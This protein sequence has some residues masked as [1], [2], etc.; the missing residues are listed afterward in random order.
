MNGV[1]GGMNNVNMQNM[2]GMQ[3]MNGMNM[4]NNGLYVPKSGGT[5]IA[6]IMQNK[7]M[8]EGM[9][10]VPN[11][12]VSGVNAMNGMHGNRQNI[13]SGGRGTTSQYGYTVDQNG[14]PIYSGQNGGSANQSRNVQGNRPVNPRDARYYA[15]NSRS[16]YSHDIDGRARVMELANDVNESLDALERSERNKRGDSESADSIDSIRSRNGSAV[17]SAKDVDDAETDQDGEIVPE[18]DEIGNDEDTDDND[19]K[20]TIDRSYGMMIIEPLLLLTIYVI[21]SQPFVIGFASR[22]IDQ[23]NPSDE[24]DI[25]LTGIII[26]GIILVIMFLVLRMLIE[27]RV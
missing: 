12:S 27:S 17:G 2:K 6:S 5:S 21:L 15:N 1:N 20:T 22:Y 14:Y 8:T 26:Y 7:K 19:K 13:N 24:G 18:D 4:Q 25:G 9:Q 11:P 23:L 3:N 16:S 10:N